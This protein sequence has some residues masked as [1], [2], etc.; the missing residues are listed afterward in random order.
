VVEYV[1]LANFDLLWDSHQDVHDCPWTNP[2]FCVVIDHHF[3]LEHAHEEI[4]HLNVEICHV[5]TYI[6]DEDVLLCSKETEIMQVN[7]GLAYQVKIYRMERGHFNAW[8]MDHFRKLAALPGFT[9]SIIPGTS[10][11]LCSGVDNAM[12]VDNATDDPRVDG[13]AQGDEDDK[14]DQE[15]G[16]DDQEDE[17][18]QA[19]V[20]VLM[21]LTIDTPGVV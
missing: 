11:V 16:E 6:Q 15:D 5:V 18:I 19:M 7:P 8:H 3:K 2:A 21:S 14:A 1:F 12:I 4:Q 13:E 17:D 9:G 20:S 10:T